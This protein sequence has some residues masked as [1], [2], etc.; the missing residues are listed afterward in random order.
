MVARKVDDSAVLMVEPLVVLTVGKTGECWVQELVSMKGISLVGVM[1]EETVAMWDRRSAEMAPM[2]V[3][4]TVRLKGVMKAALW[5]LKS[6]DSKVATTVAMMVEMR[7]GVKAGGKV[8]R[9]D[10]QRV[11][12]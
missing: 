9:K 2:L 7:V 1:A 3:G 10:L 12:T 5:V 11:A 6:A 4:T 8:G